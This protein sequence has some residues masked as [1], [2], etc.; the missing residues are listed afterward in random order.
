MAVILRQPSQL[1]PVTQSQ[2]CSYID[3]KQSKG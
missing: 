1:L 3:V 2:R